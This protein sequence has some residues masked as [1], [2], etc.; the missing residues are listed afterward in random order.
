MSHLPETDSHQDQRLNNRPP[1]DSLVGALTGLSETLFTV[2]EKEDRTLL[3][4]YIYTEVYNNFSHF[5]VMSVHAANICIHV[6]DLI[7]NKNC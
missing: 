7:Q 6:Q 1:Q 3:Y 4:Q 2:L 5:H